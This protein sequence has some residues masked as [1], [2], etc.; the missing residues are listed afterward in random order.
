V[1][2][3]W[4]FTGKSDVAGQYLGIA[5]LLIESFALDTLWGSGSLISYGLNYAPTLNLFSNCAIQVDVS[6][7][8]SDTFP[9]QRWSLILHCFKILTNFLVIYRVLSGRAWTRETQSRLSSLMWASNRSGATT[10]GTVEPRQTSI[11][12]DDTPVVGFREDV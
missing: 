8:H 6:T 7:S 10:S 11:L 1:I 2:T 5:A 3:T 9:F 4:L 12:E